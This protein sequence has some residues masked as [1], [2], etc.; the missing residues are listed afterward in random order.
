MV[1]AAAAAAAADA[2]G[3]NWPGKRGA[4]AKWNVFAM[5]KES[6]AAGGGG[7][8]WI[9]CDFAGRD[10]V[11]GKLGVS[12][13]LCGGDC[14]GCGAGCGVGQA[15]PPACSRIGGRELSRRGLAVVVVGT[16]K[17]EARFLRGC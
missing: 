8:D 1:G 11:N 16:G 15:T 12:R 13:C 7:G 3:S 2:A 14:G 5:L 4:P 9:G 6:A 17:D 10:D